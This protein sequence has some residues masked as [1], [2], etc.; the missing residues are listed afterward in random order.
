VRSR[1]RIELRSRSIA[2]PALLAVA[3]VGIAVVHPGPA[4][5]DQPGLEAD[6]CYP[7]RNAAFI[8]FGKG[9]PV[10]IEGQMTLERSGKAEIF[11]ILRR[12]GDK[13]AVLLES[14][15]EGGACILLQG[16][17]LSPPVAP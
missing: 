4:R 12:S 16:L 5:S 13:V 2:L 9:Q 7:T 14:Q 3:L 8:A 15:Q 1:E 17:I 10:K 6:Y 11:E